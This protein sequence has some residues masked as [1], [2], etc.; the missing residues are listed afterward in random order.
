MHTAA[1]VVAELGKSDEIKAA[2]M[3][4]PSLVTVDDTKGI[5]H[6]PNSNVIFL[7]I[8]FLYFQCT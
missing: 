7:I 3:L 6:V 8:L 1:K 5:G 2:V 4:H